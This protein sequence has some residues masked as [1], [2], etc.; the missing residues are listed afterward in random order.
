MLTVHPLPPNLCPGLRGPGFGP[1]GIS[2]QHGPLLPLLRGGVGYGTPI[3]KDYG[4]VAIAWD[5]K[6]S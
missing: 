3:R 2:E 1:A 6:G 5:V 4:A